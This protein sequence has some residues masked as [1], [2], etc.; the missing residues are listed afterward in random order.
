MAPRPRYGR[1]EEIANTLTHGL[2]ALLAV[3]GLVLVVQRALESGDHR[4]L[5]AGAVYGASLVVLYAASTL[6]HAVPASRAKRLLGV[7]DHAA[8]YL[9][10]AGTYTPFTLVTL[11]GP[12]GWSVLGA[13]WA[14]A[15][16]GIIHEIVRRGY[17]G[18][19]SLVF[20]LG[21]GWIVVVAA[22]PL[23]AALPPG[24]L[25]LLLLGGLF[26]TGGAIVYAWRRLPWNHAIWHVCVLGGSLAHFVCVYRYV[27]A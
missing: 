3:A 23:V 25:G 14:L 10:I 18:R 17:R 19:L 27:V 7:A 4:S 13:V 15:V 2:G 12:W 24:G 21:M 1:S 22:R 26:Y 11:R 5:V 8:I 9:L 6:Y 20:Y 16:A